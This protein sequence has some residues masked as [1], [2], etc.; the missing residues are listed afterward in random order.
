M[1]PWWPQDFLAATAH[2]SCAE[3]GAYAVLLMYEWILDGLPLEQAELSQLTNARLD[4]FAIYWKRIGRKFIQDGEVLRNIRLEEHRVKALRLRNARVKGAN[5]T[6]ENRR[7]KRSAQ[8]AVSDTAS[9]APSAESTAAKVLRPTD[10]ERAS[11]SPSPS[12][13]LEE[14]PPIPPFTLSDA[15]SDH[16]VANEA[17]RDVEG[18]NQDAFEAYL[19][20][21]DVLVT[22][23][24]VR[25]SLAPHSRLAQAKWL[26]GQGGWSRQQEIVTRAIRNGWKTLERPE[27]G[28]VGRRSF[29]ELHKE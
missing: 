12:P 15:L 19:Q 23:G 24:Q 29:D 27:R 3:R 11:P 18:L 1:M 28:G 21:L 2:W 13:S 16:F 9:G 22:R 14:N 4:D 6:N 20:H 26:A 7:A 8:R 17:W 5:V 10:A 25:A